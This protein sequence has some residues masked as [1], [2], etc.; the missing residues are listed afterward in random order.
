M[1]VGLVPRIL[2]AGGII[3]AVL[4][5][6]F[7]LVRHSFEQVRDLTRAEQRAEQS[8]VAASRVEKLILDLETGTRGYVITRDRR[9]LD[10]WRNAQRNLPAESRALGAVAPAPFSEE[11][12][13]QWRSYLNDWSRPL[14]ALVATRPLRAEL[15]IAS[16]EG[17]RRVDEMRRLIDPFILRQNRLAADQR[18]RIGDVED[19]DT[20]LAA[21]GIGVTVL[22]LV[23]IMGYSCVP[24]S[25]RSGGSSRAPAVSRPA[26]ATSRCRGGAGEV[27]ELAIAFNEMSRA[28]SGIRAARRP[29]CRPRAAC[30][31]VAR[32]A[33]LDDRRH[34]ALRRR[35]ERPARE[36]ARL[37]PDARPRHELRGHRRRPPAFG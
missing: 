28:L 15:K 10:P 7:V 3:V 13:R 31:R 24:R 25:G 11:L 21:A 22:I 4:V 18:R 34:P 19:T 6:V 14:V 37:D 33:R 5:V 12:D 35:R 17:R 2:I 32:R 23:G 36:P 27:G 26:S 8:V 16:G 20:F 1:R 30:Q 9:F 29:E